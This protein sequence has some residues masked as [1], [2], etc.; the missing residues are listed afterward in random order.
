VQIHEVFQY[1]QKKC[2]RYRTAMTFK[3]IYPHRHGSRGTAAVAPPWTSLVQVRFSFDRVITIDLLYFEIKNF[4][5]TFFICL[6]AYLT[7]L[8][9]IH[10]PESHYFH[11]DYN[12]SSVL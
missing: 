4:F 12:L 10:D 6:Y 8:E 3:K 9:I 7:S 11:R 1:A 2:N 5:N